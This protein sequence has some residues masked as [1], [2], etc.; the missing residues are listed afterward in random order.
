MSSKSED[1]QNPKEPAE[2]DKVQSLADGPTFFRYLP[3]NPT[4]EQIDDYVGRPWFYNWMEVYATTPKPTT[5]A[6]YYDDE[7]PEPQASTDEN[8]AEDAACDNI[9][10]TDGATDSHSDSH[11]RKPA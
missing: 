9:Q 5:Y 7:S 3:R 4:Q 1:P 2:T 10:K 11:S 6:V 8:V